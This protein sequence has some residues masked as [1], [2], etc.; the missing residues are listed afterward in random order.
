MISFI[1]VSKDELEEYHK[2][3]FRRMANMT[4][5]VMNKELAK[6]EQGAAF[7]IKYSDGKDYK[8]AVIRDFEGDGAFELKELVPFGVKYVLKY[9]EVESIEYDPLGD[10]KEYIQGMMI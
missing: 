7:I 2:L 9:E 3:I 1:R 8:G 6:Y 10:S 4:K 5:D